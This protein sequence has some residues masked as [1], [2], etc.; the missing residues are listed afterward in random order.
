MTVHSVTLSPAA[1]QATDPKKIREAA[2]QFESI[3][4]GQILQSAHTESGSDSLG[5]LA[6]QQFATLLAQQGGLGLGPLITQGLT[7]KSE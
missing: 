7:K 4:I 5:D 2:L 6:N 3:L 1:P